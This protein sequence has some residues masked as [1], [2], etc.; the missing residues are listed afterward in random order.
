MKVGKYSLSS[1][2]N[3]ENAVTNS[4]ERVLIEC[5]DRL[6]INHISQINKKAFDPLKMLMWR[7]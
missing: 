4:L 5:L 6:K 3:E 2:Q 1:L 7:R